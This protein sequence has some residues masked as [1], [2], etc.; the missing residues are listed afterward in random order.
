VLTVGCRDHAAPFLNKVSRKEAPNYHLIVKNPMDLGTMSKKVKSGDYDTAEAFAADLQLIFA[1][2]RL[3]NV[4]PS[5]VFLVHASNLEQQASRLLAELPDFRVQVQ[6]P[7]K[8]QP[9]PTGRAVLAPPASAESAV[10]RLR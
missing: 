3:Y 9:A 5:S 6:L 1:N 4:D 2:C 8:S 10:K 7:E